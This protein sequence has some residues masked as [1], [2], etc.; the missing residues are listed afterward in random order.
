MICRPCILRLVLSAIVVLA[1]VACPFVVSAAEPVSFSRE[2]LPILSDNCFFCHGPDAQHREAELRLDDRDAALAHKAF[3]PGKGAES[4]LV[5]RI[6]STDADELMP[7]AASNRK[8][9][10]EQINL[11]KRWIDEGAVWGK[12]WAYET[13]VQPLLPTVKLANWPRNPIDG[14]VLA[15]LEKEGLRPSPE[16]PKETLLRRVYLDLVGLPPTPEVV[17]AFLL[18]DSPDALERVVDRLLGSPRYGERWAWDWLDAAR[19]ADSSGYQGDPERTM[20]PW[21]DWVARAINDNMPYDR[22]TIDQ[23]AGDLLPDA[24]ADQKLATGFNRNHMFNAEGG[25]IA[26]ETRVENVMDRTETTGTVWLGLTIGCAGAT[27]TSSIRSPTASTTSCT[28]TSIT[29]P[30]R[31]A[32]EVVRTSRTSSTQRRPSET[33]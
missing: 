3:V 1:P 12:H 4:E 22:F 7:P 21:R 27:I 5:R 23:L 29:P 8:L 28:P 11:L 15:R 9:L 2:I 18:D 31:G 33:L 30:R 25:R 16:A 24:S 20:W 14:F 10:P 17:D 6:T 32:A 13:P 19:Y 26:E